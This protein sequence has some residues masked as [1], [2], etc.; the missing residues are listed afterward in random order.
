MSTGYTSL[1]TYQASVMSL[2]FEELEERGKSDDFEK[3]LMLLTD[4]SIDGLADSTELYTFTIR[5][6]A[7]LQSLNLIGVPS[8]TIRDLSIFRA[9]LKELEVSNTGIFKISDLL[10]TNEELQVLQS[11]PLLINESGGNNNNNNEE[12]LNIM[13]HDIKNVMLKKGDEFILSRGWR[14][15]RTLKLIN[16][17]ISIMDE[18]FLMLPSLEHL[19]LSDNDLFDVVNLERCYK[20]STLNLSYNRIDSLLDFGFTLGSIR[21]LNLSHNK[22]QSLEGLDRL[23]ALEKLDLRHNNIG[24]IEAVDYLVALPRFKALHLKG[25]PV[26]NSSNYRINVLSRFVQDPSILHTSARVTDSNT[27]ENDYLNKIAQ[28]VPILDG[29][30]ASTRESKELKSMIF[31]PVEGQIQSRFSRPS[32]RLPRSPHRN[33]T[34][35]GNSTDM[36]RNQMETLKELVG[37]DWELNLNTENRTQSHEEFLLYLNPDSSSPN[38]S[39]SNSN[40]NDNNSN[41]N[42]NSSSMNTGESNIVGT[43]AAAATTTTTCSSDGNTL[44]LVTDA[45]FLSP[46]QTK[47]QYTPTTNDSKRLITPQSTS[48]NVSYIDNNDTAIGKSSGG[49]NVSFSFVSRT[50]KVMPRPVAR[51]ALVYLTAQHMQQATST[52]SPRD[53][54]NLLQQLEIE[55]REKK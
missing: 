55:T 13:N 30:R 18:S 47:S 34:D 8:S 49:R 7:S 16:C 17:D 44:A 22:I 6:F 29:S 14:A 41:S 53:V 37:V 51:K 43:P 42:S 5:M 21:E 2:K 46:A 36:S 45:S 48:S 20:L 9:Q 28:V 31:I 40:N 11:L 19:D 3:K 54:K 35:S 50:P 27:Q 10:L 15:M 12:D 25:C 32:S 26:S 1:T 4:V 33:R 23:L 52:P 39:N 38:N 24:S